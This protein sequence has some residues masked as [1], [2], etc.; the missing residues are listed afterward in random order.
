M[1]LIK[2]YVVLF[3]ELIKAM[4]K[5][6]LSKSTFLRGLQCEKSL[7]LYK[8]RYD[9]KDEITPQQQAIFSQGTKVGVLAQELFPGG[10]DAGP[11]NYWEVEKGMANTKRLVD[12]E[13]TIIYEA[14]FMFDGV[15]A[16]MD[17]LV[18]DEQ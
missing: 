6:I 18:K 12:E 5:P 15:Y 1:Y 17:I 7:W 8:H 9:L 2:Y 13:E 11:E 14:S 3:I 10:V 16:A 4:A